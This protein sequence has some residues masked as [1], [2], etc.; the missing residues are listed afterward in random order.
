MLDESLAFLEERVKEK[1]HYK[2]EIIVVSDG[3]TD[4]TVRVAESY[5]EKYGSE[6]VRCLELI[7][8]RGKGGAVRMVS[9]FNKSFCMS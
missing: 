1:P 6:K 3:S 8:N 7:K 5:S 4:N 9:S 2:Y